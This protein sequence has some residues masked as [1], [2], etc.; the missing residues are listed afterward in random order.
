MK[1]YKSYSSVAV[2]EDGVWKVDQR[3]SETFEENNEQK[4]TSRNFHSEDTD[5]ANAIVKGSPD[6]TM[7]GIEGTLS[8]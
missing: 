2:L 3:F 4:T 8:E 1:Y 7:L 6:G 5:Y